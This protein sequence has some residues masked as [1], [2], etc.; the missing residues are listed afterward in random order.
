MAPATG[1]TEYVWELPIQ[2]KV[3]P[4]MVPGCEGMELTVTFNVE[5][6]L[7]P[8]ELFAVTD[9]VPLFPG[10]PVMDVVD[11]EPVHPEGSDHE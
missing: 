5:A 6:V 10:V 7:P 4:V 11:E 1:L 2:I 9:M 8:Q 3:F